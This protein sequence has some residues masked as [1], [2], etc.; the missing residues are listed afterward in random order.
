MAKA[1]LAT[2]QAFVLAARQRNLSRA[3]QQLN[4][5]VS[6]LS[7]QIRGLEE[8]LQQT[9]FLR[10]PR[11]VSLTPDGERLLDAVAGP[12]AAIERALQP[13]RQSREGVLSLSTL[14]TVAT[15]W[16]VPRLPRFVARHPELELHLHSGAGL[17]DFSKDSID[18][19]LRFG[20][21]IWPGLE[22][23]HLFD[24]WLTPVASPA[25]LKRRRRPRRPEELARWPLLGDPG[26]WWKDWF[27]Q[28]G[29]APP[30]RYAASFGDTESLHRAALEGL[31]VALGRITLVKPLIDAGR[32][33]ILMPQRI[34]AEWSH[35]LVYPP[36]SAAHAGVAAFRT[37][38]LEEA[39]LHSAATASAFTSRMR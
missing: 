8:R 18:A 7:H 25:F 31:G 9:L 2:L 19:A 35:Y 36:R 26:E 22:A 28:F 34:R 6:A 30:A 33:T 5:T 20:P 23:I 38:L 15:G 11:G 16:L 37:W 4:L 10:G 17:V 24:E 3:A 12:L 1:P 32:L 39:A 21:G 29:G 13:A 14:P 27:Q